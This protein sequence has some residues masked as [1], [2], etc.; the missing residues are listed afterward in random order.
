MGKS[1]DRIGRLFVITGPM[2]AGKTTMLI[3]MLSGA[4]KEN[5]KVVLFKSQVDDR[6]S[7]SDVV[8][9]DGLTFSA[10]LLP[11]GRECIGRLYEAADKNDVI[12]I[13]EGQFWHGTE[14]FCD[15]LD[16]IAFMG[17]EIYI[18]LLNR[19]AMGEPFTVATEIIPKADGVQVLHSKCSRCGGKAS[20]TQRVKDG[21][22]QFG[23]Q[24]QIGGNDIYEARCRKCFVMP[25]SPTSRP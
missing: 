2:F 24:M 7:I 21:V 16:R 11:T 9:H 22:E 15:A 19:D 5:K 1:V 18:S 4:V 20:L 14:G 12:G 8:T 3:N 25:P 17:K 10:Y 23:K 6:Y 13:D